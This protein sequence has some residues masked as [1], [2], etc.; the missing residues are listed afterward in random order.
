M[1]NIN[2]KIDNIPY[3]V[4]LPPFNEQDPYDAYDPYY[5]KLELPLVYTSLT[6]TIEFDYTHALAA[7]IES[8]LLEGVRNIPILRYSIRIGTSDYHWGDGVWSTEEIPV[9]ISNWQFSGDIIG[10]GSDQYTTNVQKF[11]VSANLLT[12]GVEYFG[13]IFIEDASINDPS[14]VGGAGGPT[15]NFSNPFSFRFKVR[16]LP[17]VSSVAISP[18]APMISSDLVLDYDFVGDEGTSD[19]SKIRWFK[20]GSEEIAFRDS[21]VINSAYLG[22]ND[23]WF[24]EITPFDGFERLTTIASNSVTIISEEVIDNTLKIYP[25]I[26]NENS[27]L[28]A[29]YKYSTQ[30]S[31]QDE[32]KWYVNDVLQNTSY[33]E[34]FV[35]LSLSP[36][37][38]VYYTLRPYNG[39]SYGSVLK[40]QIVKIDYSSFLVNE[41][42]ING[43]CVRGTGG[44]ILSDNI[45]DSTN[46]SLRWNIIEPIGKIANY[47]KIVISYDPN[48]TS[49]I[50]SETITAFKGPVAYTVP[51]GLLSKGQSYYLLIS[52]GD[53]DSIFDKATIVSFMINGSK[54]ENT[55]AND[56]GWTIELSMKY[57]FPLTETE[58][59]NE[60]A[61][62][63]LRIND[64]AKFVEIRFYN[65]KIGLFSEELL[66][67]DELTINNISQNYDCIIISGQGNNIKIY[68]NNVE[69]I[70]GTG[71]LLATSDIKSLSLGVANGATAY[72]KNIN[73]TTKGYYNPN[74]DIAFIDFGYRKIIDIPNNSVV[75]ISEVKDVNNE[76]VT[77]SSDILYRRFFATTPFDEGKSSNIYEIKEG[78]AVKF[79]A[80]NTTYNPINSI[81]SSVDGKNV[82]VCHSKG[83]SIIKSNIIR[84]WDFDQSFDSTIDILEFGFEFFTNTPCKSAYSKDDGLYIMTTYDSIKNCE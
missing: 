29:D 44:D 23:V 9:N 49:N 16:E 24:A 30:N 57:P 32:I 45:V 56:V 65:K 54:W 7:W 55:V 43:Q 8:N 21:R 13:E 69:M 15:T 61:Y 62:S 31:D 59:F 17:T 68:L 6:P 73:Y 47:A 63:F 42:F 78:E 12:R 25:L 52:I 33:G 19:R 37:D 34:K 53:V 3:N 14:G 18:L 38:E 77:T 64:G 46:V 27:I 83:F 2:L 41:L 81:S 75:G 80:I 51:Q 36:N 72:Y 28:C 11:V 26:P 1:I 71:Y 5:N 40:S 60:T 67:S 35:R 84:D 58:V 48:G 76:L 10:Y 4:G 79:P 20:N 39:V 74:S 66:L 50:L 22:Y 70:D 82:L